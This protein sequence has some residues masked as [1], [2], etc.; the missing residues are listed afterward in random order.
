MDQRP[1]VPRRISGHGLT[2][3]TRSVCG[4]RSRIMENPQEYYRRHGPMTA[5]A[6]HAAEFDALPTGVA[7]LCEVIQGVI[8]RDMAAFAYGVTLSDERKND[9]HI[10]P[11]E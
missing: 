5:M 2:E 10:R 7:A 11:V 1:G 6:A 4:A 3:P 9:A 8:H